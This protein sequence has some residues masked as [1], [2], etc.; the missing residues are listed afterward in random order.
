MRTNKVTAAHQHKAKYCRGSL[1]L[2][3]PTHLLGSVFRQKNNLE[4][5]HKMASVAVPVYLCQ[6]SAVAKKIFALRISRKLMVKQVLFANSG[7][8]RRRDK[9]SRHSLMAGF[10]SYRQECFKKG[11]NTDK[12]LK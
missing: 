12:N 9:K 3:N 10:R 1:L 7:T 2:I 5:T 4:L 6:N 11:A 8:P